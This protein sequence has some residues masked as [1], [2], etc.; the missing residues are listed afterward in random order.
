M[1][2]VTSGSECRLDRT[3]HLRQ[4]D[5]AHFAREGNLQVAKMQVAKR[6]K[7]QYPNELRRMAAERLKRFASIVVLRRSWA[8]MGGC[9]E[10]SCSD[11][12]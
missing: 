5:K 11:A 12:E 10:Q 2:S 8:Y 6:R 1:L 7:G 3:L 4:S 9:C